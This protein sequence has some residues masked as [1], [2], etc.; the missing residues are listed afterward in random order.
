MRRLVALSLRGE[1]IE[2]VAAETVAEAIALC[3]SREPRVVLI[4]L[5]LGNE[6][7]IQLAH[8]LR[9]DESTRGAVLIALTALADH[10]ARVAATAA[11]FDRY[12]TKPF[13]PLGLRTAIRESL[14]LDP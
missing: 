5:A 9:H 14:G 2:L 12:L 6:S 4:D 10:Q 11:G 1:P 7:G 13:S 8:A 3:R